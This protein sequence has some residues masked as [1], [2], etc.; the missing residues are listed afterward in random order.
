[1]ARRLVT[2]HADP[3]AGGARPPELKTGENFRRA[4]FHFQNEAGEP[5]VLRKDFARG[6]GADKVPNGRL[7]AV[8][9][10][11]LF[12]FADA[13]PRIERMRVHRIEGVAAVALIE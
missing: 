13:N 7:V 2:N 8:V 11:R 3:P 4:G 10:K 5:R 6:A 12:R 1:R 9:R